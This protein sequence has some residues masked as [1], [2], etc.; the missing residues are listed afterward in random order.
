M[1]VMVMVV[2]VSSS[3]AFAANPWTYT[4]LSDGQT[5]WCTN[6]HATYYVPSNGHTLDEL[7]FDNNGK[8]LGYISSPIDEEGDDLDTSESGLTEDIIVSPT[9]PVS[10]IDSKSAYRM[11]YTDSMTFSKRIGELRN[12]REGAWG[13]ISGAQFDG[14]KYGSVMVG[15]DKK[16][17]DIFAGAFITY[18][19]G[20]SDFFDI[21]GKAAGVYGVWMAPNGLY[22]DTVVK[23][24][25]IET[26]K[27]YK[28]L[29]ASVEGG[30]FIELGDGFFIIPQAQI[31][32]QDYDHFDSLLAR[33][34]LKYG[35]EFKDG[36]HAFLKADVLREFNYDDY[37]GTWVEVGIGAGWLI[38]DKTYLYGELD[39]SFG[40]DIDKELGLSLGV[41][42]TL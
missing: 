12:G 32:Y 11:G 36:V 14:M 9:T 20:D 33:A 35:R 39:R 10:A 30:Q 37:K 21:E 13:R 15:Y 2:L 40:N 19:T 1:M 41:R 22:I 16:I 31:S 42:L 34:G 6:G 8:F 24:Q 27:K 29:G 3:I 4:V 7:A 5:V 28:G 17:G 23:Y 38:D 18:D 26:D 25:E